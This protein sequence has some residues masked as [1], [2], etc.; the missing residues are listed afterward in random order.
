[1]RLTKFASVDDPG[2]D[3]QQRLGRRMR[4]YRLRKGMSQRKLADELDV[5]YQMVQKYENGKSRISAQR[6]IQMARIF[7]V[8]PSD[9][10][11]DFASLMAGEDHDPFPGRDAL[12][13]Q[14]RRLLAAFNGIASRAQRHAVL[15]LLERMARG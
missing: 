13:E 8:T 5:T 12:S 4:S 15:E 9:F 10:M 2:P 6:V 3:E 1:M 14:E 11:A 7:D